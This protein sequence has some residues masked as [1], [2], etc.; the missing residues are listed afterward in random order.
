MKQSFLVPVIGLFVGVLTASGCAKDAPADAHHSAHVASGVTKDT[1][2]AA[3]PG[4]GEKI[5]L[6][7]GG[8]FLYQFSEKPKIGTLIVKV[9][10]FRADGSRDTALVLTGDAGMPSMAGAH[11][12]GPV[13]F[14]TNRA[15]DYLLPVQVVMGGDWAITM[16]VLAPDGKELAQGVIRFE[17]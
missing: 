4:T 17:I 14:K 3:F 11:D 2:G 7:G 8:W 9:Q 5:M 1:S 15:G 13:V 10:A 12:S 6:T 16:R